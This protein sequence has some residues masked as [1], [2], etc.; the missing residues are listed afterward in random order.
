MKFSSRI[1]TFLKSL[2]FYGIRP[3]LY[4]HGEKVKGTGFGFLLTALL[5]L[6]STTCFVYFGQNLYFRKNPNITS[7]EE[8]LPNPSAFIIDP[9]KF[10]ILIELN[11]VDIQYFT[12]REMF[13]P[14]V[15]QFTIRNGNVSI[16]NYEMQQCN[17]THITGLEEEYKEYFRSKNLSN[18][19]CIP[20]ELNNLTMEGAFDQPVFQTIKFSFTLCENSQQKTCK[21]IDF[22]KETM[23]TGYMGLFFIDSAIEPGSYESPKKRI[24]KEVFTNFVLSSQKEIDI[25]FKNNDILSEIGLILSEK[26]KETIVNYEEFQEMNFMVPENEFL[27]IYLKMKQVKTVYERSY[28]KIQDLLGQIGGFLNFFVLFGLILNSFYVKITF[29]T[30][31]L[32]DIFSIKVQ[33]TQRKIET[34][35]PLS[36][37]NPE[38]NKYEE[39]LPSER[40]AFNKTMGIFIENAN[41]F[42]E[43]DEN[44]KE[45]SENI[46]KNKENLHQKSPSIKLPQKVLASEEIL[47]VND[48]NPVVSP[49][50]EIKEIDSLQLSFLDYVYFYTGLFR[51][52]QREQKKLL[53]LKGEKI[54]KKFLDVKFIVQKFY[55]IEKLKQIVL[56]DSQLD[57]FNFLPKP[58]LLINA[59]KQ[60]GLRRGRSQSVH[61]KVLRRSNSV[62]EAREKEREN[63]E[64]LNKSVIMK[65]S[66]SKKSITKKL[67]FLTNS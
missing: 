6:F 12:D 4:F 21:N 18:F 54:L 11:S 35:V 42:E 66:R 55:E 9:E 59:S 15:S 43:K 1:V 26:T 14:V 60:I 46:E 57:L 33:K 61:T 56:T 3:S 37:L 65:M 30:D 8:Y 50:N 51:N 39:P 25:Y 29:I 27:M 52:E 62:E 36:P 32:L 20:K 44:L 24:P 40:Q 53:I 63:T 5:F 41:N 7:H 13:T 19:F 28:T 49:T 16:R 47:S 58:E 17:E 23:K 34:I 10:P 38:I 48:N 2:D 31:I 67:T 64:V 22:I 45:M